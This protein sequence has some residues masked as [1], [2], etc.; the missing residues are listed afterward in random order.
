M[1]L[2]QQATTYPH[3]C[4]VFP[5]IGNGS[6]TGFF[7][8]GSELDRQ[9]VYVSFEAVCEMA[10][11][12]GWQGPA[13]VRSLEAENASAKAKIDQLEAELAETERTIAAID[14]LGSKDFVKRNKPG[15]KPKAEVT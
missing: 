9:H 5:Q 8:T 1:R 6:A 10:R 13:A 4:A 12:L 2:V 15:R 14:Y 7:D 11:L 3:R